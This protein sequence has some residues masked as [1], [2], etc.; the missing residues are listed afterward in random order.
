M[1]GLLGEEKHLVEA[2]PSRGL[3]METKT[4]SKS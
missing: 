3:L 4:V 1:P 2:L